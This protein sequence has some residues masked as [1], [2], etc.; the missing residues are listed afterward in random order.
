MGHRQVPHMQMLADMVFYMA[1]EAV[2][3]FTVIGDVTDV[4]TTRAPVIPK[5]AN[6]AKQSKQVD[7]PPNLPLISLFKIT[8]SFPFGREDAQSLSLC[9]QI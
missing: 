1:V 5:A 3:G 9:L 4:L 8:E 2:F 7:K 6:S